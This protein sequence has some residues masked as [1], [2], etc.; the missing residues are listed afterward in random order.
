MIEIKVDLNRQTVQR[1]IRK[2]DH[3]EG[4]YFLS[5]GNGGRK[6]IVEWVPLGSLIQCS[7]QERDQEP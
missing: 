5:V 6:Q 3:I 2:L 7:V 4:K 1:V